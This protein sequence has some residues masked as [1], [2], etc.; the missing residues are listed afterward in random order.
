MIG[1]FFAGFLL[2]SAATFGAAILAITRKKK[3]K[4]LPPHDS[5]RD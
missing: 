3:R 2:G 4:M 1:V 5:D